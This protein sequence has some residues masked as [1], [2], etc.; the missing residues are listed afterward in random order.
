MKKRF[1]KI[2]IAAVVVAVLVV[3][4][5]YRASYLESYS[6]LAHQ[7]AFE[8]SIYHDW[9]YSKSISSFNVLQWARI[10]WDSW[11]V[12]IPVRL[13]RPRLAGGHILVFATATD[14]EDVAFLYVFDQDWQFIKVFH[15]PLA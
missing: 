6:R 2:I 13:E 9:V 12:A 5:V 7:T 11:C 8:Q 14:M 15:I 3:A 4:Y 10:R 1:I